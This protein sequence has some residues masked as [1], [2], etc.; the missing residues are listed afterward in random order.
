MFSSFYSLE[1][2]SFLDYTENLIFTEAGPEHV[3]FVE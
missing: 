1:M 2:H 3:L